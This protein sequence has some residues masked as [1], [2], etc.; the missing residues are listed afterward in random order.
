MDY[1]RKDLSTSITAS[2][3][4]KFRPNVVVC[5]INQKNE[6]L[7]VH[8]IDKP[9]IWHLPQ[10]G[11]ETGE[12]VIEAAGRELKEELGVHGFE[13]VK[14]VPEFFVYSWPEHVIEKGRAEGRKPFIGQKQDL[15]IAR[16]ISEQIIFKTDNREVFKF[17]WV[18]IDTLPV[19]MHSS[20]QDLAL[21]LKEILDGLF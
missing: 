15:V 10:G 16:L 20:R 7:L 11:I 12:S 4:R 21:K 1:T 5:L 8:G 17:K 14:L 9:N 19:E 2:A 6:V 3:K 13:I 18:S